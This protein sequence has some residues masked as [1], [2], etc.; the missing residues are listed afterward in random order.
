MS[1]IKTFRVQDTNGVRFTVFR[2]EHTQVADEGG[3]ARK[4]LQFE[5]ETGEQGSFVD[6]N[7]FQLTRSG[8]RLSRVCGGRR[9]G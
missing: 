4:L 5:L 1:R 6:E 7:T 8:E 3:R 2:R 9:K